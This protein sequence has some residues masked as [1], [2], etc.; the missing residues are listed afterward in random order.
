MEKKNFSYSSLGTLLASL[1]PPYT[2]QEPHTGSLEWREKPAGP[3][4]TPCPAL[5][6]RAGLWFGRRKVFVMVVKEVPCPHPEA[7]ERAGAAADPGEGAGVGSPVCR[8]G[9]VSRI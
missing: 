2:R 3:V 5:R 9:R 7:R 6:P 1:N 8:A 4:P